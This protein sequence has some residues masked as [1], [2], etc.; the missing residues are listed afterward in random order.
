VSEKQTQRSDRPRRGRRR[1][2]PRKPPARDHAVVQPGLPGGLYK[3][4]SNEAMARVHQGVLTVLAEVGM[5]E[6]PDF[7]AD[8]ILANG[9]ER[10]ANGRVLF[11]RSLTED[12]ISSFRRNIVLHGRQPGHE[13]D[14][15]GTNVHLGTGGAAPSMVDL[16]TGAYRPSTLKDLYDAARVVDALANIHFF[17]RSVVARDMETILDFDVNTAFA[18]LAGT[19]KHVISMVTEAG[20][21]APVARMCELIAGSKEKFDEQPFLS[22]NMNH[23]VPPLRFIEDSCGVMEQAAVHGLPVFMNSTG[24]AGASGPAALAGSVV[25]AVAETLAGMIFMWMVN[26]QC[27]VVFGPRPLVTDLRTGGMTGGCGEQAVAMA[28]GVQMAQFY[29]LPNSCIAG[30]TDSKISDA[31]SGYEKALTVS[32]AAHAGSNMV[33]QACGMQAALMGCSL[34]AYVIDNDMLGAILRSVRGIEVSEA[35]FSE[36]VIA[37]VTSGEGHFLGHADTMVRM[38]SDFLY[39]NI[40]DRRSSDEWED[41]GS[42]DIRL[43]ARDRAREL[44][45]SHFPR[46]LQDNTERRIRE[47]FDIHLLPV[48]MGR[49]P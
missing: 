11:P 29:D 24:Q 31:Q 14:L 45:T 41:A 1:G 12:A 26:P 21:V 37:D 35:D 28:A 34:E 17:S 7:V 49:A 42:P 16:E 27:R 18:C 47:E 22:L 39:P 5:G 20:H 15:S 19:S 2:A 3:P 4:L 13:L 10:A 44:L 43:P 38:E 9:G 32:L 8:R 23:V 46:H 40:A 48:D 6:A 25:Q 33:T 36:K 30:A